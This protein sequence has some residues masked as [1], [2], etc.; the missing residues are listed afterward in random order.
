MP[1][2]RV[3]QVQRAYLARRAPFSA[4]RAHLQFEPQLRAREPRSHADVHLCRGSHF[5][6]MAAFPLL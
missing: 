2:T 1:Q 4:A 3:G 6:T 5:N